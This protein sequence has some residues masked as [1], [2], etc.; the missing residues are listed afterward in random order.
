MARKVIGGVGRLWMTIVVLWIIN[1][2]VERGEALKV[3]W[4]VRKSPIY[5]GDSAKELLNLCPDGC[6]SSCTMIDCDDDAIASLRQA[7]S[8]IGGLVGA[9]SENSVLPIILKWV[10]LAI[11]TV[12]GSYLFYKKHFLWGS[13]I[14][15]D[16]MGGTGGIYHRVY[17]MMKY[18][19]KATSTPEA[20]NQKPNAADSFIQEERKKILERTN[21]E[22]FG[23]GLLTEAYH[24]K[25]ETMISHSFNPMAW[26]Q[27]KLGEI[28]L[29]PMRLKKKNVHIHDSD[30][31]VSTDSIESNNKLY[32]D[33]VFVDP[34]GSDSDEYNILETRI[35]AED[36]GYPNQ[37]FV[38]S[39]AKL[40]S[41]GD[42]LKKLSKKTHDANTHENRHLNKIKSGNS[43]SE[44]ED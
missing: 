24:A 34:E 28:R 32:Y 30:S 18:E 20:P 36:K 5:G 4:L 13:L 21:E 22:G 3:N 14:D 11:V 23:L 27:E 40:R 16:I 17:L 25:P 31:D 12:M 10:P 2:S 29:Q 9:I 38:A 43:S 42:R 15:E 7:Q 8:L 41:K 19:V 35:D 1:S 33:T 37:R 44:S 26:E 39:M 6:G